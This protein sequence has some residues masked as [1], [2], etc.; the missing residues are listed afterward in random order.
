MFVHCVGD[1]YIL[2]T[3]TSSTSYVYTFT[4]LNIYYYN[5]LLIAMAR[6]L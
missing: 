4:L 3:A 1:V 2:Q 5:K 6:S